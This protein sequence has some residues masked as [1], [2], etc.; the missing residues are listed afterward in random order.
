MN[1]ELNLRFPTPEQVIVRLI[2]DDDHDES[3]LLPFRGPLAVPISRICT[4]DRRRCRIWWR[5]WR[6]PL[7][8]R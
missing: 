6:I 3:E 2:G 4:G 8:H 5:A 1:L 7:G